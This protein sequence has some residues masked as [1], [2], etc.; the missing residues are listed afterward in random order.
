MLS[1][2]NIEKVKE[3]EKE[4]VE[5]KNILF[6]LSDEVKDVHKENKKILRS[7][8]KAEQLSSI[9]LNK[10][11]KGEEIIN[12]LKLQI[13]D[14]KPVG[15]GPSRIVHK[16]RKVGRRGGG[17]TWPVW[18]VQLICEMLTNGAPPSA[19]PGLIEII[20][21]T[22]TGEKVNNLPSVRYISIRHCQI[23]VKILGE[24]MEE[25]KLGR[26]EC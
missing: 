17:S 7:K 14:N 25:I 1:Q 12:E 18:I 13:R 19:I 22:F 16:E 23:L 20:L 6:E 4:I 5:L 15:K 11:R 2:Q 26:E 8:R 3:K 10:V 9:R 24:T 21:E